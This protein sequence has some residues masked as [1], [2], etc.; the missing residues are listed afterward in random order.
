[1]S[2]RLSEL[3]QPAHERACDAKNVQMHNDPLQPA[4]AVEK[5]GNSAPSPPIAN[6]LLE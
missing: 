5:F 6:R 2:A 1:M 4:G 3:S